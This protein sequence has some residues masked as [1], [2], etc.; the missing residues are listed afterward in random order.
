MYF[1][2]LSQAL[3]AHINNIHS[4]KGVFAEDFEEMYIFHP[5]IN[6]GQTYKDHRELA[7]LKG[8]KTKKYAHSVIYRTENGRYELTSYIS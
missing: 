7:T 6:Y 8:K 3:E 4:Q 2:T 5:P 1:D